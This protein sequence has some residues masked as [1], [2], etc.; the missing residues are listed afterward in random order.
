MRGF[1]CLL[2]SANIGNGDV[3]TSDACFALMDVRME[4]CITFHPFCCDSVTT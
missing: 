3:Y 4:L 1:R 2:A